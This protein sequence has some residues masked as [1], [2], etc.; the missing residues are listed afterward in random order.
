MRQ[1]IFGLAALVILTGAIFG[2]SAFTSAEVVRDS[3]IGVEADNNAII[4]LAPGTVGDSVTLNNN[5]ELQINATPGSSSGVNVGANFTY[6][7]NA[8][9]TTSYAFSITNADSEQRDIS[10][11]YNNVANNQGVSDAVEFEVYDSSGAHVGTVTSQNDVTNTFT[12][13]STYYVVMELH[14]QGLD[15][16]AD[17][18][19]DLVITA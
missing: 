3:T 15:S 6:G 9:P 19:G 2:A 12:S 10:L 8:S 11:A 14:T 5:G 4:S 13:G 17:L 1:Y 7:D 16:G 18:S